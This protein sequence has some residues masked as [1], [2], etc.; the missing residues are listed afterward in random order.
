M[1]GIPFSLLQLCQP[2]TNP[3]SPVRERHTHIGQRGGRSVEELGKELSDGP[4]DV[5]H[6]CNE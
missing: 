4:C 2:E 6:S 3:P 1:D 5:D